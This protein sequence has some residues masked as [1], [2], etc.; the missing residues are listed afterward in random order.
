MSVIQQ[1][2]P[3]IFNGGQM[4][5]LP[6]FNGTIDGT[7]L[8]ELVAPGN[9][10]NGVNY[11]ITS[12]QLASMLDRASAHPTIITVGATVVTP[13]VAQL[14]DTRILLNKII[15]S[16]SYVSL[17][18]PVARNFLPVMVRDIKGD[19]Q[20]ITVTFDGTCDGI[21]GQIVIDA[22]YGGYYFNPLNNG[23]WYLTNT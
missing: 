20:P 14:S 21:G 11:R 15:P 8:F 1:I 4:T 6:L 17:G 23:N 9:V 7:E 16:S 3:Q 12:T 2:N 10:Q 18:S 5:D 19:G 13:Y 22:L